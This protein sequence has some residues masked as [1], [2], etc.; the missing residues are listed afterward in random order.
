MDPSSE[1]VKQ[2]ETHR[3][4]TGYTSSRDAPLPRLALDAIIV[5]ASR[6]AEHLDHA[7]ML[8]RAAGCWLL[9]LCSRQL[10]STDAR[11]FLAARSFHNAI[12]VDL[13][14]DY[15]HEL[16]SF[17]GL[18][19]LRNQ[20]PEACGFFTTD[21]S[22]KRN[23]GLILAR[24]LEW[25]RVFFLDDDIRDI[26]PPDLQATVDMLGSFA[27]VGMRVTDFP[28]N[29]IVCHANRMTG[30]SQ[31]VFVSGA[32][33]AVN[34]DAEIGYFPDIYN[35]DWL[36]LFDD[37]VGGK[38]GCSRVKA[39]QLCY[40][41]FANPRR[42]AW[43]EFGDVF[44]EGLYALLHLDRKLEHATGRYWASF[45]E[46]RRDFLEKVNTASK[47][48]HPE[49]RSDIRDAVAEAVKC[50]LTIKPDLC[51]RYVE[52]WRQDL[53]GWKR[54]TTSIRRMSIEGALN[55][56]RLSPSGPVNKAVG[57]PHR[58]AEL[59]PEPGPG[60]V[61]FP[62]FD[63]LKELSE[64]M[65]NL[66]VSPPVP[67]PANRA[68]IPFPILTDEYSL[69]MLTAKINGSYSPWTMDPVGGRQRKQRLGT[70]VVARLAVPWR[71]RAGARTGDIGL[72][73][74]IVLITQHT[75]DHTV[76]M[77]ALP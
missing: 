54:R 57:V 63:T 6:P 46:A 1:A 20:L 17:P 26:A 45:L 29:S 56:M 41:P 32:A 43:Q 35:E 60:R 9:I 27:A 40:Y 51:E 36:F 12:V 70:A 42:A 19:S 68:T 48:A 21:L 73:L 39:T 31:D 5:P 47:H 11:R 50:L 13:P 37:L 38:V 14:P 10:R 74:V 62:R 71:R 64:Y 55:E 61:A 3:A 72:L 25:Q 15:R 44:A 16:L 4:L 33:L 2:H 75:E 67:E 30:G 76:P 28:D 59:R 69:A 77:P 58:S 34:C 65:G 23:V 24:M 52:L 18:R 22:T 66:P 7:V 8:A 49:M 53:D